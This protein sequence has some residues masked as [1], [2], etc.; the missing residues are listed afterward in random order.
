MCQKPRQT[1]GNCCLFGRIL[2]HPD[3]AATAS[4]AKGFEAV[5]AWGH[6]NRLYSRGE[7]IRRLLRDALESKKAAQVLPDSPLNETEHEA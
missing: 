2:T 4:K 1:A 5:D 3:T 7:A 6:E